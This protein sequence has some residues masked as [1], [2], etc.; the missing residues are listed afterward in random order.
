[1]LKW[2]QGGISAVTGLAEPEYG[3]EFI[4]SAADKVNEQ[5][6]NPFNTAT[7]DDLKWL[8]PDYTNVETSTFYVNDL[9][10]GIIGLA[11]V[12]HSNIVGLHQTAQFNCRIVDSNDVKNFNVW[13]STKLENFRI[14]GT[15]FYADNL[16]IELNEDGNQFH[17]VANVNEIVSL[18]LFFTRVTDGCKLGNDPNTY[19]GDNVEEPW[20]KIRHIF[21]PRNKLVGTIN[22]KYEEPREEQGNQKEGEEEQ[23]LKSFIEKTIKFTEEKP[24]LSMFVLA[25]QGMKPH[26]AAKA[27]NFINFQSDEYSVILIEFI[28]PKSYA[29]T[30][31]SI[32]I[33]TDSEKILSVATNNNFEHIDSTVDSIGWPVPKAIKCTFNGISADLSDDQVKKMYGENNGTLKEQEIAVVNVNLTNL[34]ERIDVMNEIPQFVK[35]IVSGVAGTK[36]YIYQYAGDEDFNI[37]INNKKVKGLGM[38][39]VIFISEHDDEELVNAV[40]AVKLSDE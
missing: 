30:K 19:F 13:T 3:K 6:I 38:L 10:T 33:V 20:G 35:N 7:S 25:F 24:A 2:I 31:V 11:Q 8:C 27:W 4:H 32:G 26:H 21:W 17:V 37:E 36:P 18:D 28:T 34:I 22:I 1:M 14:D 9:N 23:Q 29:N 12:I 40:A 15:N 5:Q 39:E 16:K